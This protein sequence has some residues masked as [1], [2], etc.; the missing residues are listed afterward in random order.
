MVPPQ[1]YIKYNDLFD[2]VQ[3]YM[4]V[5][6]NTLSWKILARINISNVTYQKLVSSL[7]RKADD[8]KFSS[9]YYSCV[10]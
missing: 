9:Y 8:D 7:T 3:P 2:T 10:F 6:D 5:E 4:V 1:F